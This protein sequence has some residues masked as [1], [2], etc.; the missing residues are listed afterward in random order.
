MPCQGELNNRDCKKDGGSEIGC[1]AVSWSPV[2][3]R[4]IEE[5]S[6]EESGYIAGNWSSVIRDEEDCVVLGDG[7][8]DKQK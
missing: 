2:K 3:F 1:N 5:D 4:A 7:P 6:N 8:V